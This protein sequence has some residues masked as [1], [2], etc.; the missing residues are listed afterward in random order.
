VVAESS[1]LVSELV[2]AN[3]S[4]APATLT[5]AYVRSLTAP[6]GGDGVATLTL[7]PREQRVLLDAYAFLREAGVPVGPVGE[8]HVGT[9]R[10]RVA[11]ASLDNVFAAARTA[12]RSGTGQFGL[13]S[14][15]VTPAEEAGDE[16]TL[17]GLRADATNRA[18]AAVVNSGPDS[19]GPDTLQHL[20]YDGDAGG[21]LKG[22]PAWQTLAPG[23]HA[24]VN[25]ILGSAGIANGWVRVRR[26]SGTAPWLA[27][28][29]VNDGG[30]PGER[31][32]DGA[33]VAMDA[34]A[35]AVQ[36]AGD[37]FVRNGD[38][39]LVGTLDLPPTPGPHPV[40]VFVAGSGRATRQDDRVAG[41]ILLPQ[42]IGL[43]TYDKRG[44]SVH[45]HGPD[46]NLET[47]T[48]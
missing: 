45:G 38:V 18:N 9:L 33:Y 30:A 46:V 3:R 37:F 6:A 31:T 14:P 26:V 2:L 20:T 15:A 11:G 21:A 28:G 47:V 23:Q 29:V 48:G 34:S 4:G 25:Q 16:V 19:A 32:G 5:L 40:M 1:N 35:P 12:F 10:I 13:F 39:T 42:G 8:G 24:Q 7:A 27:Y 22:T 36:G 17:Y 44:G 43:F 41:G